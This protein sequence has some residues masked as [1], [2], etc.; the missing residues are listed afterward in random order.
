MNGRTLLWWSREGR[1]YSRNAV[2]RAAIRRVGWE[3]IDFRPRFSRFGDLQAAFARLSR[4]DL[5]WVPCFRQRDAAAACRWAARRGVPTVFDPLISA[6]DKQVFERQKF[7]P[8][9]EAARR[10]LNWERRLMQSF[11]V[12]V[13][14]TDCHAGF[15][16]D[17][18]GVPRPRLQVVP[19]GAD[20]SVFRPA[21]LT[22]EPDGRL[23]VLFYGSFIGL[24]GA[25]FIAEAAAKTP[26]FDWTLLGN[27]PMRAECERKTSGCKHVRYVDWMPYEKLPEM[28]SQNHVVLG[29]FGD[30]AKAGNVIP[31][32]VYQALACGRPVVTRQSPAYPQA[33]RNSDNSFE[34]SGIRFVEAGS[35]DAIS[36]A[37]R[38]IADSRQL[39]RTA[40]KSASACFDHYFSS[41]VIDESVQRVLDQATAERQR[42]A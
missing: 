10:L 39:L 4:P 29:V 28:I 6:Y 37:L 13:A 32:K 17:Q 23:Q 40:G 21:P 27:G 7:A 42:A 12:V 33:V 38:A 36:N 15:F 16:I 25:N 20:E 1:D 2:V 41:R 3:I 26:E 30:G 19:V 31:N 22:V 18:L 8:D 34:E 11:D 24:Q 35:A 14:D 5:V 9:S